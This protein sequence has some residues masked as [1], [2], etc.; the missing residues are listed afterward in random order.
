[1]FDLIILVVHHSGWYRGSKGYTALLM[2]SLAYL[3]SPIPAPSMILLTQAVGFI[4]CAKNLRVLPGRRAHFTKYQ[5]FNHTPRSEMRFTIWTNVK[6]N[7]MLQ[8]VEREFLIKT[9]ALRQR[10]KK[11]MEGLSGFLYLCV[12]K[13]PLYGTHTVNLMIVTVREHY[14]SNFVGSYSWI[15]LW[16]Y[17]GSRLTASQHFDLIVED[18]CHS[19]KCMIRKCL[20]SMKFILHVT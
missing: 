7:T 1:M 4:M 10:K 8:N 18:F 3:G 9:N 6:H 13:Y 17:R 14:E 16:C 19:Q 11:H 2:D 15:K 5:A 12:I 20:F